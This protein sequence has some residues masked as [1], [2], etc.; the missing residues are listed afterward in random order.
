MAL[1]HPSLH[2]LTGPST[3]STCCFPSNLYKN[4]GAALI[5]RS[6]AAFRGE[7]FDTHSS[8]LRQFIRICVRALACA[9]IGVP[10]RAHLFPSLC[11]GDARP[12]A[13]RLLRWLRR[14][15][16]LQRREFG[17]VLRDTFSAV[18]EGTLTLRGCFLAT[19][20]K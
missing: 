13:S 19:T 15:F 4:V 10:A 6:D 20:R 9:V 11:S 1:A 7:G 18:H 8:L 3:G 16:K 17:G 14:E 2:H 12:I 5:P